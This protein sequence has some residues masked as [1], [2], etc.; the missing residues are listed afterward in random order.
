MLHSPTICHSMLEALLSLSARMSQPATASWY[1]ESLL[2]LMGVQVAGPVAIGADTSFLVPQNLKLG[3]FVS[4]GT[5]SRIAAWGPITIGDDFIS[6]DLLNL[7]SGMH[8]PVTLNPLTASI[9]IGARVWCGTAVTIC[10]GVEIGDD[11]VIGAGSVVT[12]SLE[13]NCIAYGVP[14]K[15]MRP[16]NRTEARVWSNWPERSSGGYLEKAPQWKRN[17]HWMRA[18]I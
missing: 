10:G 15:P 4:I 8:D 9:H 16:L 17:M 6:S 13:S 18:R 7:N 14:A 2:R 11:V 1:Q 3:S 5:G 12:K